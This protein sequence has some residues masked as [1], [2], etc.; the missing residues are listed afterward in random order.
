MQSNSGASVRLYLVSQI[1]VSSFSPALFQVCAKGTPS[2]QPESERAGRFKICFF[3]ATRIVRQRR[4]L[5]AQIQMS[6]GMI[7]NFFYN[8]TKTNQISTPI[9]VK[10]IGT[11]HNQILDLYYSRHVFGTKESVSLKEKIAIVDQYYKEHGITPLFSTIVK[12]DTNIVNNLKLIISNSYTFETN[13]KV[14][15]DLYKKQVYSKDEYVFMKRFY[16]SIQPNLSNPETVLKIIDNFEGKLQNSNE[17]LPVEKKQLESVMSIA[18][19]SVR[20]WAYGN[21]SFKATLATEF[22]W[23]SWVE[24]DVGGAGMA[25]EGGAAEEYFIWTG[26]NPYVYF[27]TVLGF[28]AVASMI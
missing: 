11:L 19:S 4:M 16:D 25:V 26:G 28:A 9:S 6:G 3:Q 15:N 10:N 5:S 23:P 21:G 27:G 1:S 14:I 22:E 7:I 13:Y 17:Y 24:R 12:R 2:E 18:K 8:N 20:Y